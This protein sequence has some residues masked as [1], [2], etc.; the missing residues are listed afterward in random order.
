MNEGSSTQVLVWDR[1]V[2]VFHWALVACMVGAYATA[3]TGPRRWHEWLGY[4]AFAL[5]A[6]RLVW[7]VVGSKHAR[8][9]NFVPTPARL[10]R[11]LASMLKRQEPRYLG[12]NPAMAVMALLFLALVSAIGVTGWML[13]LDAY[14]GSEAVENVHVLLVDVTLVAVA[15]HVSAAVYVSLRH[16]ENLIRSMFTG[17]KRAD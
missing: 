6:A 13:T 4:T 5:V 3:T 8:F 2:R 10:W 15:V 17:H 14:W 9:A 16:R 12:H 7:G 11:Y 1:F